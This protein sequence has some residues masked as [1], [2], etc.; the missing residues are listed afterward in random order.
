MQLGPPNPTAKET[1]ETKNNKPKKLNNRRRVK[2]SPP[3]SLRLDSI[4]DSTRPEMDLENV[5]GPQTAMSGRGSRDLFGRPISG[6]G[7][8]SAPTSPVALNKLPPPPN[9]TVVVCVLAGTGR[10]DLWV[11][12][13][14]GQTPL[15]LCPADQPLRRALIKCCDAAARVRSTQA[16]A[17]AAEISG[18]ATAVAQHSLS[19]KPPQLTSMNNITIVPNNSIKTPHREACDLQLTAN[20][21][22]PSNPC[23]KTTVVNCDNIKLINTPTSLTDN[24]SYTS[25]PH[26]STAVSLH[27]DN[28]NKPSVTTDSTVD[29]DALSTHDKIA[30]MVS[31]MNLD[32]SDECNDLNLADYN[33]K[34]DKNN[35]Q[36]N[37][38]S[39]NGSTEVAKNSYN[40]Y[41]YCICN[42][43]P[44]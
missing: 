15:D 33:N 27:N 30:A 5:S 39:N 12:N 41:K 11:R 28:S 16:T 38:G 37:Y 19:L 44:R 2:K 31:S 42:N 24:F 35:L 1:E 23:T 13:N 17:T 21:P 20:H 6:P 8:Q 34:N 18:A 7:F 36:S 14:R 40:R 10:A 32:E 25:T 43:F 9:A 29:G 26:T 3:R 4:N 22:E